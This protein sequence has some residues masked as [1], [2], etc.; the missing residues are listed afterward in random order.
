MRIAIS[1]THF[2]GKSTLVQDLGEALPR[3]Y[4]TVEEPYYLL[5]EEGYEFSE[6]PSIEDFERQ[7]E[8]SIECLE[9]SGPNVVFDRC[10]VDLLGYLLTHPEAEA[11]D[12]ETWLPSIEAAMEMLDLIIFLPIEKRD[13]ISVPSSQDPELRLLVDEKIRELLDHP[14]FDFD[15]DV[16]EVTGPR[17]ERLR[18]V[19]ALVDHGGG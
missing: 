5:E 10:P 17:S 14:P 11:F 7:L 13:R 16:V 15:G 19:M 2:S 6:E 12:L 8:R 9:E 4:S 1:G 18:R 3:Q